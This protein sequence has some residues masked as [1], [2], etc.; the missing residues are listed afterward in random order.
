MQRLQKGQVGAV[1]GC[2]SVSSGQDLA[3]DK[4]IDNKN[5]LNDAN[6]INEDAKYM[7]DSKKTFIF[8]PFRVEHRSPAIFTGGGHE[9]VSEIGLFRQLAGKDDDYHHNC[10]N[11]DFGKIDNTSDYSDDKEDNYDNRINAPP[12]ELNSLLQ[13]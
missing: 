4:K 9:F 6:R 5:L 10:D 13:E 12:Q 3:L 11:V 7:E 2:E 1:F 8:F